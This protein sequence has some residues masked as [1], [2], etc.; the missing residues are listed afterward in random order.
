[1]IKHSK[2]ETLNSSSHMKFT[3]YK[4]WVLIPKSWLSMFF[5]FHLV[6]FNANNCNLQH[7]RFIIQGWTF[8][9]FRKQ[10]IRRSLMNAKQGSKRSSPWFLDM[11]IASLQWLKIDLL[12]WSTIYVVRNSEWWNCIIQISWSSYHWHEQA[13]LAKF[14][15][16]WGLG[17]IGEAWMWTGPRPEPWVTSNYSWCCNIGT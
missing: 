2:L 6:L 11:H 17:L 4:L 16:E 14:E 3:F 15:H 7:S 9:S 8:R 1:M 10:W 5:S 12:H 13:W